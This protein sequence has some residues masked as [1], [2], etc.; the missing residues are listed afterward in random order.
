MKVMLLRNC[1][2]AFAIAGLLAI[3]PAF[4]DKPSWAGE[5]KPAFTLESTNGIRTFLFGSYL[6]ISKL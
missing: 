2:A 3:H 6:Y 4:A 5:G 1:T